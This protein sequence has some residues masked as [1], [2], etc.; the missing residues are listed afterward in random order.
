M[1]YFVGGFLR[2]KFYYDPKLLQNLVHTSRKRTPT[3]QEEMPMC[4]LSVKN[5]SIKS[6]PKKLKS[7]SNSPNVLPRSRKTNSKFNFEFK[8]NCVSFIDSSKDVSVDLTSDTSSHTNMGS[9]YRMKPNKE[10]PKAVKN[11]YKT[12]D[13][14]TQLTS[15]NSNHDS[16]TYSKI[17]QR[18]NVP[19]SKMFKIVD[20][21]ELEADEASSIVGYSSK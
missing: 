6:S 3:N 1:K 9:S 5:K 2:C 12:R 7:K 21:D 18:Q 4:S 19:S 11:R 14:S 13:Q 10:T 8:S 15:N 20:C 17:N 16:K